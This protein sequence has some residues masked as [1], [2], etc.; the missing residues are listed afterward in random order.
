M[1]LYDIVKD[2]EVA[3]LIELLYEGYRMP[4]EEILKELEI[5]RKKL[6]TLLDISEGLWD[7][8]RPK[9][10]ELTQRGE[11][12]YGII[13]SRNTRIKKHKEKIAKEKSEQFDEKLKVKWAIVKGF[14]DKWKQI[15]LKPSAFFKNM[16]LKG[17]YKEPLKFALVCYTPFAILT[18]F[19]GI[20]YLDFPAL[21]LP[22]IALL[23]GLIIVFAQG[24]IVHAGVLI[25]ARENRKGFKST[26][27]VISYAQAAAVFLWIP[28]AGAVI[29]LYGIRLS[30]AGLI[31]VHKTTRIRA[32]FAYFFIITFLAIIGGAA[33]IYLIH[34]GMAQTS[35]RLPFEIPEM[36]KI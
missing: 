34:I 16:S 13:K 5:D 4:Y 3:R 26:I 24:L 31:K 33:A 17:G 27:K 14:I 8:P 23:I 36:P 19:F 32:V 9:I 10:Y 11:V 20:P 6:D 12:A 7:T 30:I 28:I 1:S 22:P 2:P 18:P 21:L 25:F 29:S 15:F 35:V